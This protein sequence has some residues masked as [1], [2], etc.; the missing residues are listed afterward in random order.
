M[1]AFLILVFIG[2]LG[3]GTV[4]DIKANQARE[5]CLQRRIPNGV[6]E[7][8]L[9]VTLAAGMA[10]IVAMVTAIMAKPMVAMIALAVSILVTIAYWKD[11]LDMV[12]IMK[13]AG[14][15]GYAMR[16]F[17]PY[18]IWARIVL[19]GIGKWVHIVMCC[20]LIGIPLYGMMQNVNVSL[21]MLTEQMELRQ[22]Y[23][24]LHRR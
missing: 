21:E 22:E 24:R 20:T 13:E 10:G 8:S 9:P 7:Y 16:K 23:E 15:S 11:A 4:N 1:T 6:P 3:L 17:Q 5:I 2:I 14:W 12:P 18:W 19:L